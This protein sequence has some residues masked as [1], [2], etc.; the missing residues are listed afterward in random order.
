MSLGKVH[1]P[2]PTDPKKMASSR[3]CDVIRKAS[4]DAAACATHVTSPVDIALTDPLAAGSP[5]PDSSP[6][7][8]AQTLQM[9][10][11]LPEPTQ[12]PP[13]SARPETLPTIGHIG[14]YALKYRIGEG[15]LGTV[16]AAHD[17]LLSRLIAVKTLNVDIDTETRDTFNQLF[18]NEARAAGS[19]SHPHIVT[20]F[21]AGLHGEGNQQ[22]AYIAMELLK[23]KDLRQLT[24]DGWRPTPAQ[25]ALIVRRVADA[26]AYAHSRGVVHCDIKPAN[27]FMVG[28]AQPRV[29][30]F[31]IA[32]IARRRDAASRGDSTQHAEPGELIAGSPYYMAPEQVRN[33]TVDRRADV[34]SLGVV[35]YEL[36]TGHRPF[37]GETLTAITDAVLH[38]KPP[39]AHL[40][41]PE[42]PKDLSDIAERAMMRNREHRTHSAR[43]L[44]RELR[45]WLE[46]QSPEAF[47]DRR[48][49]GEA[50]WRR[51]L[52]WAGGILATLAVTGGM[53]WWGATQSGRETAA[54]G[55]EATVQGRPR[56]LQQ[57]GQVAISGT[58]DSRHSATPADESGSG[59]AASQ[60]EAPTG[61][62]VP[63]DNAGI[64]APPNGLDPEESRDVSAAAA[65]VGPPPAGIS[66][67]PQTGASREAAAS[68]N[69]TLPAKPPA[70][71]RSEARRARANKAQPA[72][73]ATAAIA[74][75]TLSI[76]VSPWAQVEVNG[77]PAGTA[78]PLNRLNLSAG[79]H[80]VT[81]RNDAYPPYTTTVNVT[82]G[83][84]I[85]IR[86]RFGP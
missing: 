37:D 62:A 39:S 75:G 48:T 54:L 60:L 78:P 19:L 28:R 69:P 57:P 36:L 51:R 43:A 71:E 1:A 41:D 27:I 23:G 59:S 5:G 30:D 16:Y 77:S 20:V 52:T 74:S 67:A 81:L 17:P 15:G 49:R 70:K 40:I 61:P 21:D 11:P 72:A 22:V 25:A 3:V 26:L 38:R 8:E 80:T 47:E 9:T 42:V 63:V 24:K 44:A 14:R 68:A 35:L 13:P 45:H 50:D 10:R 33:E 73:A 83:E 34:Y 6:W 29:L 55:A 86:H 76:A 2:V 79:R 66:P 32:R 53:V 46:Q 56:P 7:D 84:T 12:T 64:G 58:G 85:T 4:W 31:G 18:L 65:A 82:A